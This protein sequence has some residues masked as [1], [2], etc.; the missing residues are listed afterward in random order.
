MHVDVMVQWNLLKAVMQ[1]AS[2]TDEATP[3]G[4]ASRHLFETCVCGPRPQ[5]N[6]QPNP[7]ESGGFGDTTGDAPAVSSVFGELKSSGSADGR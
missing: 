3:Y 1:R 7:L 2:V 4:D 5:P 6:P